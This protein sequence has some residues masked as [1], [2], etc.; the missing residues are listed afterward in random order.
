M[1][2]VVHLI[3]V[4]KHLNMRAKINFANMLKNVQKSRKLP[5][6]RTIFNIFAKLIFAFKFNI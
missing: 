1:K 6:F 3:W 2:I 5:D 4:C